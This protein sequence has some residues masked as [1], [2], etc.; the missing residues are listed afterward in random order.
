MALFKTLKRYINEQIGPYRPN[1]AKIAFEALSANTFRGLMIDVGAHFG[2][3]LKAFAHHGWRVYAF[4]PDSENRK[5]LIASFGNSENVTIDHRA[6]SDHAQEKVRLYKSYES[7]GI[8]GLSSFHT[9]HQPGEEVTVTT[10]ECFLDEQKMA[11]QTIDF[12]KIDTEGFD[13]HV[14][15]GTPWHKTSP[16]LVLCEFED[17]KTIPLGYSFHDLAH[18]L[19]QHHYH[20]IISEWYPIQKYGGAHQWRRFTTYPCELE[21][22]QAWGNILATKEDN[23]YSGLLQACRINR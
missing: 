12:L 9:S 21:D 16:R 4:E 10:L 3:S 7:T 20:L 14:L 8:S 23:V 22:P 2:G 1:E 5:K 15:K 17:L 19:S 11:K 6:V 13:L 18:F